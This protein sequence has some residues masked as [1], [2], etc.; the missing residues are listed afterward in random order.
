MTMFA[1]MAK[2]GV[3]PTRSGTW[4]ARDV[5]DQDDFREIDVYPHPQRGLCVWGE[6]YGH[7]DHDHVP[8]KSTGI[9]FIKRVRK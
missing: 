5:I 1:A 8:V 7:S 9:R 3:I 4:L 2:H 6:D